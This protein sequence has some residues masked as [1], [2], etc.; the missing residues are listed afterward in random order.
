[1]QR[2]RTEV[3]VPH[4]DRLHRLGCHVEIGSEFESEAVNVAKSEGFGNLLLVGSAL[5][6]TAHRLTLR[7]L[8]PLRPSFFHGGADPCSPLGTHNVFTSRVPVLPDEE[9]A[10]LL[11]RDISASIAAINSGVFIGD[12]EWRILGLG[13]RG[14]YVI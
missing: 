11:K 10:C 13:V 2:A 3:V 4:D 14:L 1:M 7:G 5:V 9:F 8:L 6:A 12:L